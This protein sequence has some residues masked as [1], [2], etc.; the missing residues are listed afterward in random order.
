[1]EGFLNQKKTSKYFGSVTVKTGSNE[2]T[3]KEGLSNSNSNAFDKQ[4]RV[5]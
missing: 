4:K 1:M 3:S 2:Q 5:Q